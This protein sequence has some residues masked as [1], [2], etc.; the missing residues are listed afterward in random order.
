MDIR[1]KLWDST[2]KP[3]KKG[4]VVGAASGLVLGLVQINM[5]LAIAMIPV[6]VVLGLVFLPMIVGLVLT[7]LVFGILGYVVG[8]TAEHLGSATRPNVKHALFVTGVGLVIF[9][10]AFVAV[11]KP[12]ITTGGLPI[13]QGAARQVQYASQPFETL[14]SVSGIPSNVQEPGIY[15][16]GYHDGTTYPAK[17]CPS[18]CAYGCLPNTDECKPL[19]QN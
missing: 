18:G 14:A 1:K 6:V 13:A 9:V 12:A 10:A 16:I 3:R 5:V 19:P 2:W 8:R 17:V 7:S 11:Y 15:Q 4:F